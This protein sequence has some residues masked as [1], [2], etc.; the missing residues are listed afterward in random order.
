MTF[1]ELH[2][3]IKIDHVIVGEPEAARR[4]CLAD[5]VRLVGAVDAVDR[6]A[7]IERARAQRVAGAA[8]HEPWKIR[9]ALDHF[10]RRRPIRPLR[11]L[12]Y[13]HQPRP[14]KAVAPD[15]DAVANGSIV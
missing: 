1:A 10:R 8:G 4:D 5:S 2:S 3:I 9:L 11:L 14:L 12:G 15:A 13:L 6:L 7:E